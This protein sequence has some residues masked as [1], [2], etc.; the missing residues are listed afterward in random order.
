[1]NTPLALAA[2]LTSLLLTACGGGG[3]GGGNDNSRAFST[4]EVNVAAASNG[5]KATATYNNA[6]AKNLIDGDVA[7]TWISDDGSTITVDFGTTR[8]ITKIVLRKV[9]SSVTLGSNPDILV[10]L[11]ENGS[12]WTASNMSVYSGGIPCTSINSGRTVSTCEMAARNARAIRV[13]TQN[14]K[15]FEL[16]ELEVTGK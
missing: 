14:G 15:S 7:T 4:P 1:M 6:T 2:A 5:A 11:S 3:G 13:T 10:E 16:Q 8:S 9:D 12:T